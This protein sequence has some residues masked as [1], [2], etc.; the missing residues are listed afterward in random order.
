M[1]RKFPGLVMIVTV[2]DS[3]VVINLDDIVKQYF[4][5]SS[6]EFLLAALAQ[7]RDSIGNK[8]IEIV[9]AYQ[10]PILL[11]PF[12]AVIHA[13]I[14]IFDLPPD[15]V[16]IKTQNFDYRNTRATVIRFEDP[17]N[18]EL[19]YRLSNEI[20]NLD[21]KLDQTPVLF[22]ALYGRCSYPR[23]ALAYYL[24]TSYPS[25]SYVTMLSGKQHIND[26]L[27]GF[28]VFFPE[29]LTWAQHYQNPQGSADPEC[30]RGSFSLPYNIRHWPKI[31]GKY[32]IEIIVE[33]DYYNRTDL[34]EKTWKC[35]ASGKPFILMGGSGAL[36]YLRDRGYQTFSPWIDEEYDKERDV[37]KRLDM[38]KKEIDRLINLDKSILENIIFEL[39]NISKNNA[40]IFR[41]KYV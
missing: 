7:I 36:Q 1:R 14:D 41:K 9:A 30:D 26:N 28:S 16:I 31:W 29:M 40:L 25:D 39:Y 22:G 12:D 24:N 13:I 20:K 11:K 35:L 38:I 23:V 5:N 2:T 19:L 33:T 17:E 18:A 27:G 4:I 10:T 34:S 32:F 21:F 3:S 6:F 8:N 37:W 15:R